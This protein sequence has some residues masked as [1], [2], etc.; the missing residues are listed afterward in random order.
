VKSLEEVIIKIKSAYDTIPII[1]QALDYARWNQKTVYAFPPKVFGSVDDSLTGTISNAATYWQSKTTDISSLDQN[2]TNSGLAINASGSSGL[3]DSINSYSK[4]YGTE[5]WIQP[6]IL[7]F[8]TIQKNQNIRGVVST[9]LAVIDAHI[10]TEFNQSVEIID[11]A[12][13]GTRTF[14]EAAIL[15]RTVLEHFKGRLYTKSPTAGGVPKG[16]K[17]EGMAKDLARNGVGSLEYSTLRSENVT[18]DRLHDRL[19]ELAKNIATS[20]AEDFHIL[21]VEY[22]GHIFVVLNLLDPAKI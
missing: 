6:L 2:V 12:L 16:V 14:S 19:S 5:P 1:T 9:K 3:Y 10:A 21:S 13:A 4:S 22:V 11:H 17:W 20:T 15:M 8:D 7:E 18:Y